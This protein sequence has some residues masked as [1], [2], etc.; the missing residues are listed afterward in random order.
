[1]RQ[2]ATFVE[3]NPLPLI[4]V[5]MSPQP[6]EFRRAVKLELVAGVPRSRWTQ[7]PLPSQELLAVVSLSDGLSHQPASA[8]DTFELDEIPNPLRIGGAGLFLGLPE[9]LGH[10]IVLP[11]R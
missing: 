11:C 4:R 5:A 10:G 9:R 3:R 6:I 8:L 1:M 7:K 2:Q